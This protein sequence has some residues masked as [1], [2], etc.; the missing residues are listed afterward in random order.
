MRLFHFSIDSYSK[1]ITLD[2]ELSSLWVTAVPTL[3]LHIE[4]HF[5]IVRLPLRH[6]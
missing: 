1:C 4:C 6:T 2:K 3:N 5:L